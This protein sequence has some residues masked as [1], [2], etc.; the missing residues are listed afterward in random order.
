MGRRAARLK[1][2]DLGPQGPALLALETGGDHLGVALWR[3]PQER[4]VEGERWRLLEEV[5]AASDQGH[6][7][8]AVGKSLGE[9]GKARLG[10]LPV[11]SAWPAV[12]P[13]H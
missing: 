11:G 9:A 4:D 8:S 5:R 6:S 13:P 1:G 2:R 10:S 12:V 7:A 3:L